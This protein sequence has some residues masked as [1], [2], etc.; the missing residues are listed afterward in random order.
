MARK[1]SKAKLLGGAHQTPFLIT[2]QN[3]KGAPDR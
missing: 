3:E 2:N 1:L